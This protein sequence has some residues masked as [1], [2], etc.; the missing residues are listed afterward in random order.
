MS[1]V[2][3]SMQMLVGEMIVEFVGGQAAP[4]TSF[5]VRSGGRPGCYDW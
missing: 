4:Q 5:F 1:R 2:A 3:T